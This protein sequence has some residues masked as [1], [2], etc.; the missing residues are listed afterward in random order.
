MHEEPVLAD[1]LDSLEIQGHIDASV[2]AQAA[3][4]FAERAGH[5]PDGLLVRLFQGI[6]AW[7]ASFFLLGFL[8]TIGVLND[9]TVSMMFCAAA[10]FAAAIFFARGKRRDTVTHEQFVIAFALVANGLFQGA[11]WDMLHLDYEKAS[12]LVLAGIQVGVTL[13]YFLFFSERTIRF[14]TSL[15]AL[16]LFGLWCFWDFENTW[17][18]V[19]IS[20]ICGLYLL[21]SPFIPN[22]RDIRAPLELTAALSGLGVLVVMLFGTGHLEW[23]QQAVWTSLLVLAL[24]LKA[25]MRPAKISWG[26]GIVTAIVLGV[27][28]HPSIIA[29]LYL[30]FLGHERGERVLTALGLISLPVFIVMYYYNLEFSLSEKA[31]IL[32]ASGALLLAVRWAI[33]RWSGERA[34]QGGSAS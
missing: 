25:W 3:V 27:L 9:T 8:V 6:S 14:L 21:S 4:Y 16:S 7:I 17:G 18:P 20:A 12:I 2:K 5:I 31:Y 32:F 15:C 10:C 34:V 29:A 28:I 23:P 22:R 1:V 19:I 24:A 11:C 26:I 30:L 13:V 33:L